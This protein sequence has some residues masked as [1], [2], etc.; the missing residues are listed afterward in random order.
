MVGGEP[1]TA[2]PAAQRLVGMAQ[3]LGRG[4][5]TALPQRMG[6]GTAKVTRHRLSAALNNTVQVSYT[7]C[8]KIV[9]NVPIY[10]LLG[11]LLLSV[12]DVL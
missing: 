6:G 4:R 7:V 2:G 10:H 1:G 8:N 9:R 5:V 3:P 12:T 11:A